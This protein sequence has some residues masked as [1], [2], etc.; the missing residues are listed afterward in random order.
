MT[1]PLNHKNIDQ[2]A[3]AICGE[4]KKL[5]PSLKRIKISFTPLVFPILRAAGIKTKLIKKNRRDLLERKTTQLLIKRV[6][7]IAASR[8]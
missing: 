2:V 7:K 4:K 6:S 8:I 5:S 3:R 1:K